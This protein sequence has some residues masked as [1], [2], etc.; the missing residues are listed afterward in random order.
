MRSPFKGSRKPYSVYTESL[1]LYPEAFGFLWTHDSNLI[2]T[3]GSNLYFSEVV[4][5]RSDL[6]GALRAAVLLSSH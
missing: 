3:A 6:V 2:T 5:A 4:V 1:V